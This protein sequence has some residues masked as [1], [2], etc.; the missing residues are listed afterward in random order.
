M[1]NFN[2]VIPRI[3]TNSAKYDSIRELYGV[4]PE[5]G[6]GM[7]IAD[8]DFE[9]PEEVIEALKQELNQGVFGY[10]GNQKN[11]DEALKQWL[12]DQHLW[13][14]DVDWISVTHGL[15]QA[16]GIALRAFSNPNDSVIVF[17]P[18]YHSFKK[19]IKANNRTILEYK[20]EQVQ[21]QYTFDLDKLEMMLTGKEKILI[22]C[23]PHN[24]GGRVWTI[25]EQNDLA[26]FCKKNKILLVVDEIHNDLVYPGQKHTTFQVAVKSSIS[27]SIVL[28]STTKTFNIA[29]GLIGSVIIE[30]PKLRIQFQLAHDA[31]GTTP[32]RFGMVMSEAAMRSDKIWLTNLM[33]HLEKN[34]NIFDEQINSI[35][36]LKSM[37]LQATY[38]AWVDFSETNFSE[39]TIVKLVHSEAQIAC[40]IGSTF[41]K[42]GELFMRFN[43]ACPQA[44]VLEATSRL[45]AIF[46]DL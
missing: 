4:S 14:I 17:S 29:G 36:S 44:T 37:R 41:G 8:M 43:L 26:D 6:L 25:K 45:K 1:Y 10:Y 12:L 2:R 38:L 39:A 16:I 31:I 27:N 7:G 15:V 11:Y 19:I 46:K 21:G 22:F 9:P 34:R 32:N 30:N 3:G 18:V 42:G 40:N 13:E 24:P 35:S 33:L 5:S 20:M 23:S 28:L